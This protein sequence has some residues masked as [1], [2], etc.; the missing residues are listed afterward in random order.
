MTRP[1]DFLPVLNDILMLKREE[2]AALA[3]GGDLYDALLDDYEP[4]ATQAQIAALFDAMRPRPCRA[5]RKRPGRRFPART[6][7]R[8]FPAGNP[9]QA[10]AR[11]RH[12]LRL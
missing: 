5:A 12:R 8:R 2:A 9:A 10:G 1:Q 11:L 3:D 6:A 7:E 4:G